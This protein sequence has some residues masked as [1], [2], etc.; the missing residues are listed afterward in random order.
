MLIN[1]VKLQRCLSTRNPALCP[2]SLLPHPSSSSL[3]SLFHSRLQVGLIVH[4]QGPKLA[5]RN[6]GHSFHTTCRGLPQAS[7]FTYCSVHSELAQEALLRILCVRPPHMLV[8]H[9]A[10]GYRPVPHGDEGVIA[11]HLNYTFKKMEPRT[12]SLQSP[13]WKTP[14]QGGKGH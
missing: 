13:T 4:P 10:I 6:T 14:S 9:V 1:P 7:P 11:G 2:L 5:T 12:V 8:V 3:T